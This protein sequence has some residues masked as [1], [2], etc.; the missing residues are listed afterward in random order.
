MNMKDFKNFTI[1]NKLGSEKGMQP[2]DFKAFQE[3]IDKQGNIA[4]VSAETRDQ[5]R[6]LRMVQ[7]VDPSIAGFFID[8][9]L[10]V[11]SME[12]TWNFHNRRMGSDIS[13]PINPDVL[14][15]FSLDTALKEA[16]K[17]RK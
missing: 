14:R 17:Q 11:L 15:S 12:G 6:K 13:T 4:E 10:N 3:L 1:E 2:T 5:L 7:S 8:F 9:S 16:I